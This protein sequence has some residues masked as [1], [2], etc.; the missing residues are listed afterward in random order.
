LCLSAAACAA[1]GI[2]FPT[3]PGQPFTDYAAVHSQLSQACSG[4]RTLTAEL[5]LSGRAG[6]QRL[7][8]RVVSGFE[9]PSSMR[10]EGVAPFGPPAFILVSRGEIAT[11][12]LPRDNRVLRGAR[13]D[14]ILGALTGVA[15]APADLQAIVS[16]CV[17]P[18]PRATG[19]RVHVNGWA[20][21]DLSG[22]AILYL[23]MQNGGW[24]L[25]GARRGDWDIEYS[26]TRGSLPQSVRLR[27]RLPG[28]T[29]D[30]TAAIA[31]LETNTD[32]EAAAFEVT[33]PVAADPIT[34]E[35]LREAGPL[36]GQ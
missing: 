35:E 24:Q 26:V 7:R 30:L 8:G 27:S 22:G 4:V 14:Q 21:I 9:R 1:R 5:S 20:S 36:R 31:Q 13:A 12:L 17:E 32:L 23:Q 29:V 11:L 6:S 19:G 18:A 10:L 16:G 25:R 33:V 3:D 34:L 15:L 28:T 2:S